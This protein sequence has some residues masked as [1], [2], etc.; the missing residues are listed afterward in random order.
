MMKLDFTPVYIVSLGTDLQ[1]GLDLLEGIVNSGNVKPVLGSF[2]GGIENSYVVSE[3][4]FRRHLTELTQLLHLCKQECILYLDNQRNAFLCYTA[5]GYY[6]DRIY[7]GTW[8]RVTESVAKSQEAWT[9]D[10][11]AYYIT[12]GDYEKV[13]ANARCSDQST[14]RILLDRGY[15]Q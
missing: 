8:K 10:G 12:R 15:A 3:P 13:Q 9:R 2:K 7:N 11:C 1:E 6:D 14:P 4:T 5:N